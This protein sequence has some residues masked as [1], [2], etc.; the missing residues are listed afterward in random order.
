MASFIILVYI[1][2]FR[3]IFHSP[4]PD[5]REDRWQGV[6]I[7]FNKFEGDSFRKTPFHPYVRPVENVRI[8]VIT[9]VDYNGGRQNMVAN[10]AEI[11]RTLTNIRFLV[12][13]LKDIFREAI[14]VFPEDKDMLEKQIQTTEVFNRKIREF[15]RALFY[16][17]AVEINKI[18]ELTA[19]INEK[20]DF[21][22]KSVEVLKNH[23][24]LETPASPLVIM[25]E[26]FQFGF[27]HSMPL[28]LRGERTEQ[29]LHGVKIYFQG[30]LCMRK[31][32]F[33]NINAAL[34]HHDG[35][36]CG[37]Q[38]LSAPTFCVSGTALK[39]M[40][41][42]P[43][44]ILTVLDGQSVN[45]VFGRNSEYVSI[46]F[47]AHIRLLGLNQLVN[48]TL[49]RTQLSVQVKGAIF[50]QFSAEMKIL[51]R[52]KETNDWNLLVYLV[53]GK[54][55]KTSRL[56]SLFQQEINKYIQFTAENAQ[57]RIQKAENA[58]RV[59]KNKTKEAEKL[60]ERK[61]ITMNLLSE[62]LKQKMDLLKQ[63]RVK[64]AQAKLQFNS[65]VMQYENLRKTTICEMKNCN[66]ETNACI[67]KVCRK[68]IKTS[69]SVP[70]CR[71]KVE[72]ISVEFIKQ[73]KE[74]AEY[75]Y[76]KPDTYRVFKPWP[77]WL[78]DWSITKKK[79]ATITKKY[80]KITNKV[81]EQII[82]T[83][84]FECAS[85]PK[86]KTIVS[87]Y[88]SPY[89]CCDNNMNVPILDQLCVI[90]NSE[91][92]NNM[93][94][95]IQDVER[96]E[97]NESALF[98]HYQLMTDMERQLS[99]AQMEV[100]IARTKVDM[101]SNQVELARAF[102]QEHQYAE[103]LMNVTKIKIQ[104]KLGLQ[105]ATKMNSYGVSV[106]V[107]VESLSFNTSMTSVT[108]TLLPFVATVQTVEGEIRFMEFPMDFKRVNYSIAS[109]AKLLLKTLY[110][111][112][113][114]R[115]KR[116]TRIEL[117]D[118]TFG[119]DSGKRMCL[120]SHEANAFFK[121][122]IES[123]EFLLNTTEE[124]FQGISSSLGEFNSH[125]KHS[126]EKSWRSK[127]LLESFRGMMQSLK[128]HYDESTKGATWNTI[129]GQW[130]DS[131]GVLTGFKN[132]S[133]C[134]GYQDC[135]DYFFR[136]LDEF[137]Q[138]ERS[139]RA[140]EIKQQLQELKLIFASFLQ[141]NI[142][143]AT[144]QEKTPYAKE[145]INKTKDDTV[146]CGTRPTITEGS[147]A[148]IVILSGDT[149]NLT[150]RVKNALDVEI[151]WIKNERVLDDMNDEI[152]VLRNVNKQTEGAYKCEVSNNRGRTVSNVTVVKVHQAPSI[153]EHP[154]S[155]HVLIGTEA[156]SLVCISTGV[157]ESRTEWFFMPTNKHTEKVVRLNFS[158]PLLI[159]R[160]LTP[161]DSGFYY[162]NVSNIHG[163]VKSRKARLEVL[164]FVPGIPRVMVSLKFARCVPEDLPQSLSN[165][166]EDR[167]TPTLQ[168]DHAGLNQSFRGIIERMNWSWK[169]IE[170]FH[171][172]LRPNPS[173]YFVITGSKPDAKEH[174]TPGY[175]EA[176]NSFSLSRR[177]ISRSLLSLRSALEEG[178]IQFLWKNVSI[179]AMKG[180]FAA[181]LLT[182]KC[183]TGTEADKNG[184]ICGE[185][186]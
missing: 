58:T 150:C 25:I 164:A 86:Q 161:E 153:I 19:E 72:K 13:E 92:E 24:S 125:N 126:G 167:H 154:R 168:L 183:P 5:R 139:H 174:I 81:E 63:R 26:D 124:L 45:M 1:V 36:I 4:G 57:K 129:L 80:T 97:N 71:E 3:F 47:E 133:E 107:S 181:E 115:K 59:A 170:K 62:K 101:A 151:S 144:V 166:T 41:L 186:S 172:D 14:F 137:Y 18:R 163:T 179:G 152:L 128:S 54:M 105:L 147:P 103:D 91:C 7:T 121:D 22:V 159:K 64:Y 108:K 8:D 169:S 35:N 15:R 132:F 74:D 52:I 38:H 99:L 83:K 76:K 155:M 60:L 73:I 96:K 112:S 90:H 11:R 122:I 138:F 127:Q 33:N 82:D 65:T 37:S 113:N 140:L 116:S 75:S 56:P 51:A 145:L 165:C 106:L 94:E 176:L 84:T 49:D 6:L 119:V 149:A 23:V 177:E 158:E 100:N 171:F 29:R 110:G 17:R 160:N 55:I 111:K 69:Y 162:C 185:F 34:V 88:K 10:M 66:N 173:V 28:K 136:T 175:I 50:K 117:A 178:K 109:A 32:C 67:P 42:S 146:L 85:S 157:P 53:E 143:L 135:V 48:A 182:Q 156:V 21:L 134:S 9:R 114:S 141:Q 43:G 27:P 78:N 148:E 104:E 44:K 16:N 68:E 123:L 31:L 61:Q 39:T 79:G 77:G 98:E 12:P 184:F 93:T 20:I 102:L 87:G 118:D 180:S 120:F 89:Q 95:F 142:S 30:N 40:S 131:L 70:D 46:E 130:R 2:T